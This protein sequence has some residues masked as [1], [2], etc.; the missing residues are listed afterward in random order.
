M[1]FISLINISN[2]VKISCSEFDKP[3]VLYVGKG[4]HGSLIKSI[5]RSYRPWWI[6]EETNP[7][8]PNVN[9]HWYQIRQNSLLEKLKDHPST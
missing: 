2:N 1:S 9:F 4:N 3:Y 5:F 7:D 8:N 6:I